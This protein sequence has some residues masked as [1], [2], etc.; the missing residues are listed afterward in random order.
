[1]EQKTI[2]KLSNEEILRQQLELLAEYSQQI[3]DPYELSSITGVM[4]DIYKAL[5]N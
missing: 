3:L 5:K 2:D 4:I 1:M